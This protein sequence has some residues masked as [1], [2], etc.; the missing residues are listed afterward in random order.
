M[1]KSSNLN[2]SHVEVQEE[3]KETVKH[4]EYYLNTSH[5]EVQVN[6]FQVILFRFIHLNTSHVEVQVI[7][8]CEA[9]EAAV[10]KY[11]SC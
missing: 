11:I 3:N 5:V 4:Q 6:D 9:V 2:T 1:F 10:F 7:T 8:E